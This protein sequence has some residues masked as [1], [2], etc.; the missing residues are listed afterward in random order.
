MSRG[1]LL[2]SSRDVDFV[3]LYMLIHCAK[4]VIL[5]K[6]E[7]A[8]HEMRRTYCGTLIGLRFREGHLCTTNGTSVHSTAQNDAGVD[9]VLN[10]FALH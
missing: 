1:C 8:D 7:T 10:R 6:R 3:T 4:E 9:P 5:L 2:P